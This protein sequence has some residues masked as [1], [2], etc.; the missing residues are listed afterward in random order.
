MTTRPKRLRAAATCGM[1]VLVMANGKRG[2]WRDFNENSSPVPMSSERP[3]DYACGYDPMVMFFTSGTTGYPKM[4]LHSYMY[5]IG[6]ITT[7]K[8]WQNVGP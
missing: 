1:K 3:D 8:Y 5:A 4:A 7:A 2:G 6:H